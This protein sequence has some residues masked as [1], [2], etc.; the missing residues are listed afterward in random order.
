MGEVYGDHFHHLHTVYEVETSPYRK[1][2]LWVQTL[3]LCWGILVGA[4]RSPAHSEGC[5]Q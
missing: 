4:E 3:V 5:G 1:P 2:F